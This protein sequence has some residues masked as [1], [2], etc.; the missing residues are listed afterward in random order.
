MKKY[1]L[2]LF[3]V[4]VLLAPCI[5]F[6]QQ[7]TC[8]PDVSDSYW[9][10]S[11]SLYGSKRLS[12]CHVNAYY[13]CHGFVRS[14]F[15]NGCTTPSWTGS[16]IPAPYLCPNQQGNRTTPDF[17]D[18]GK[19]V[20]V[21]SETNANIAFYTFIGTVGNH[22]AV[23]EVTGGGAITKY[24]SK[25]G[26]DGPLVAHN[27][28]GSWYHIN[29]KD[30]NPVTPIEF[31][32]YIGPISGNPSINGISPT[33]FSATSVP[34]VIYAWSIASGYSNIYISS[35][36]NQS[37]VTLTPTH[38]GTA[39]LQLSISSA[40]GSVK[41]QQITLNIQTNVCLEG[42]FTNAGGGNQNLNTT[43]TVLVGNV[44]ATVSCPNA[45]SYIWQKTSGNINSYYASGAN[46]S[47]TM[48]SGGSISFLLTAKNG[49]T[50]LS[51]RNITFYNYGSFRVSPNPASTS[52]TVDLN[53]EIPFKIVL[54]H[55]DLQVKKEISNYRGKSMI[56]ISA[57]KQGEYALHIYHE[58]KL[59]NQ[60]IV[61]ISK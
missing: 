37:T 26:T 47:F 57:L 22:S 48:T 17:K 3:S 36:S 33:T 24:L 50:T 13:N 15:E 61:M 14:Y 16:L 29:G 51:T 20:Q 1:T 27:L 19:Y 30:T 5:T 7:A 52:I 8:Y 21:C 60:Q 56:D 53:E 28:S 38:S 44:S 39:V 32:R 40:C 2:P 4:L 18:V 10:I 11:E 12:D 34:T 49:S 59:I 9:K 42:T 35:A 25:Y 46:V 45:T 58:G 55:F 23:K 6:S 41:T 54:Q 31:W 43:N